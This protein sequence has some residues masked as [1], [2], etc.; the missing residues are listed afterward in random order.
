VIGIG[1]QIIPIYF[2]EL[3]WEVL[4]KNQNPPHPTVVKTESHQLVT[5]R[6][7]IEF[8]LH[9]YKNYS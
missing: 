2:S 6:H 4:H 5:Q 3:E 7:H 9:T 8:Q 1:T